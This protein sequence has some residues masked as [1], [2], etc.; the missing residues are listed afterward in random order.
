MIFSDTTEAVYRLASSMPNRSKGFSHRQGS[1][2]FRGG[3]FF[4]DSATVQPARL[5][6][7][8]RAR[9][10]AAGVE[11]YENTAAGRVRRRADSVEVNTD[12]GTVRARRAVLAM[13][14]A[15]KGLSGPLRGRFSVAS[16][17]VVITEPVPELLEEIGWTG[18]EC[19]TDSRALVDYFRTT[20]DGRIAF[21]WGGGGS[22]SAPGSTAAPRSTPE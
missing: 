18:G 8:L 15:A 9:L 17:H 2:L 4:P 22:G 16:S 14:A 19:I 7:G 3:V 5:G 1:P 11:I 20:P 10:L 12:S 21:G 6:L 13:G